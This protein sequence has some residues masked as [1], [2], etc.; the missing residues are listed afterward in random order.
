MTRDGL[1]MENGRD[2]EKIP[3]RLRIWR[4][5]G[6]RE[7][8]IKRRTVQKKRK[9]KELSGFKYCGENGGEIN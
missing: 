1:G 6:K 7:Y 4:E 3:E 8:R 9:R 5:N 2:E